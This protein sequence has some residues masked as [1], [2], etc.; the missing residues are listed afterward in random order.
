[1]DEY[2]HIA[3]TVANTVLLMKLIFERQ[4]KEKLLLE[5][6]GAVRLLLFR[7]MQRQALQ[8]GPLKQSSGSE[9]ME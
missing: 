6:V 5:L 7:E 2:W 4:L 8:S 3:I 1:M 9:S